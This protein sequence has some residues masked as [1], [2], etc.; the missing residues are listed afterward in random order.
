MD[1]IL[2]PEIMDGEAEAAAYA[3]A[4][5]SDSNQA[6]VADVVRSFPTHLAQ[7]VDLGCGPGDIALRLNRIAATT[8]IIGVDGSSA[9]LALARQAL[10]A[11]GLE[12]NV[13]F[14]EARLPGVPLPA[15]SFDLVLS[16]DMLHHL[17]D[18]QVLWS[19]VRRLGRP[20]AAVCVVDLCRP[21]TP[22]AA[23]EIVERVSGAE[24]PLLKTDFYNSLCAAFTAAELREQLSVANLPLAVS[25]LTE[26]HLCVKGRLPG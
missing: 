3:R 16:K 18:P 23:Q 26:R 4:D 15:G 9:M 22:A 21:A 8:R 13:S 10:R 7:V 5:F 6:Y 17:P 25:Q 14:L 1:R 19:E 11:A 2:E 12:A 24:H 20:G